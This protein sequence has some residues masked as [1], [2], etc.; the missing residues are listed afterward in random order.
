M[1]AAK[2]PRVVA[3]LSQ[4][5]KTRCEVEDFSGCDLATPKLRIPMTKPRFKTW[6]FALIFCFFAGVST[7]R[8]DQ[9]Q[10]VPIEQARAI[11]REVSESQIVISYASKAQNERAEIWRVKTALV[12]PMDQTGELGEDFAAFYET[13]VFFERLF[14][15]K[16]AFTGALPANIEWEDVPQNERFDLVAIDA[17]YV[18]SKD[19]ENERQFRCI[20]KKLEFPCDIEGET[21]EISTEIAEKLVQ[22]GEEVE[23]AE[24]VEN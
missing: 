17:A 18:Y 4:K 16:N 3:M 5:T 21:I 2:V 11:S 23:V 15:S 19:G 8:A 1:R 13:H 6:I 22:A 24:I 14:R 7:V 12:A 20:G 9:L 10:A